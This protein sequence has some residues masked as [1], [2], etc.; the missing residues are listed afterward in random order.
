MDR[1]TMMIQKPNEKGKIVIKLKDTGRMP[2]IALFGSGVGYYEGKAVEQLGGFYNAKGAERNANQPT[3]YRLMA[4]YEVPA[5]L[6]KR[7]FEGNGDNSMPPFMDGWQDH[8]DTF[9][10]ETATPSQ[11][12]SIKGFRVDDKAADFYK[13][14][15][16]Y[17][18]VLK[19]LKENDEEQI[20]KILAHAGIDDGFFTRK[21]FPHQR[22]GLAFF[23]SSLYLLGC[24]HIC[25][26]DEMRTGKTHQ[27]IN[28]AKWLFREKKITGCLVIVPN[29]IKRVWMNEFQI[30]DP[31][32]SWLSTIVEGSKFE[33]RQRWMN[34]GLIWIVNYEGARADKEELLTWQERMSSKGWLLICDEAHKLKNIQSQQ[35]QVVLDL[36]PTY[37]IFMTGTPVANRPEDAFAMADFVCPGILGKDVVSFQQRFATKGGYGGKQIVGYKDLDEVKYRMARLSMRRLRKDIM[38]DQTIYQI[39]NGDLSGKQLTAYQEMRDMLMAELTKDTGEWT[40]V[41]AR[42]HMTK[43]MRL[44]Q[45]TSG[46]LSPDPSNVS[47][48][49]ENWKFTELD[50]FIEEY[51]DDIGKLVIW[52]RWVPVIEQLEKRYQRHGAVSIYGQVVDTAK[53]PERTERMYR[54]QQNPDCKIMVAQILSASLGLGF[55]PATFA[56]FTDFWWSPH[57]NKQAEDRILGIK[58]PV[59]VTIIKLVTPDTIDERLQ[60]ILGQKSEWAASVTG[61]VKEEIELPMIDKA[62]LLYLLSKP[63]EAR[64]YES[65]RKS[66]DAT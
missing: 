37:S 21:P 15:Q 24:G 7:L 39:R 51:L 23:L 52:S 50:E 10:Y 64:K 49:D 30:D 33:K 65:A 6:T 57:L 53:H 63:E 3:E 26:F 8:V 29:T 34:F 14:Y 9:D 27:A 40:V 4:H 35:S 54:F 66:K 58:N 25:L 56:I 5:P 46:Y 61:D 12:E 32:H 55:Q 18:E 2:S 48:F 1:G 62:T 31:E 11:M 42:S 16:R 43:V 20:Q 60:F 38:F 44:L 47:W 59:P 22:S 41:K 17:E 28:I 36:K 45:I 13:K 19:L